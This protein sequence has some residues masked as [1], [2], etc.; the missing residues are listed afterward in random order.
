MSKLLATLFVASLSAFAGDTLVVY[1]HSAATV[2]LRTA[3]AMRAET[4]RLLAPAGLRLDWRG[5]VA[6]GEDFPQLISLGLRGD[7]AAGPDFR[8]TGPDLRLAHTAVSDGKVLPFATVECGL[9]R[10]V[11]ARQLIQAEKEEREELLGR[12]LGRV[13]AHEIYHMVLRTREHSSSG[14]SRPC[15]RPSDLTAADFE[16]DRATVA[17]LQPGMEDRHPELEPPSDATR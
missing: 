8:P 11:L 16:F 2:P 9:V 4:A 5:T 15:F 12:A 14:A 17:L 1:T 6:R 13:V 10:K 7:C 3:E